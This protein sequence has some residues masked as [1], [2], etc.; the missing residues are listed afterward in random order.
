MGFA[1]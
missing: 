1:W